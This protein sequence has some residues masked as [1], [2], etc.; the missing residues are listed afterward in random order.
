[1]ESEYRKFDLSTLDKP[2][3]T[4]NIKP[5]GT[6]AFMSILG[7][8]MLITLN[9]RFMLFGVFILANTI[10]VYIKTPDRPVLSI[11]NSGIVIFD[12]QTHVAD[13]YI[14]WDQITQWHYKTGVAFN[15][16]LT[17]TCENSEMFTIESF[18]GTRIFKYFNKFAKSKER[19]I[20][21]FKKQ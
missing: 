21:L 19:T 16:V 15:D 7:F 11:Y 9:W 12:R 2:L 18:K 13:V 1:M 3:Y 10:F 17:I 14:T 8:I 20:Q 5:L 4:M 6:L